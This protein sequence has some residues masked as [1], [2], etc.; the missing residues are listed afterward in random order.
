MSTNLPLRA[1]M[2]DRIQVVLPKEQKRRAF[3]IAAREGV[4][5]C[6]L[7]RSALERVIS[8]RSALDSTSSRFGV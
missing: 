2:D 8:E 5:V 6:H 3:E 4:S 7:I 1:Q